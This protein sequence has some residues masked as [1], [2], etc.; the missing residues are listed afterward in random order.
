MHM[1]HTCTFACTVYTC[2]M[3][4]LCKLT[5]YGS[6]W[7]ALALCTGSEPD[8]CVKPDSYYKIMYMHLDLTV[9]PKVQVCVWGS[10]KSVKSSVSVERS[11]LYSAVRCVPV[12]FSFRSISKYY[13]PVLIKATIAMF[14][15]IFEKTACY[16]TRY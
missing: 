12:L 2:N 14:E 7:F 15:N 5:L 8:H 3:Q 10:T 16:N 13:S 6:T 4:G 9:P 1:E 11:F